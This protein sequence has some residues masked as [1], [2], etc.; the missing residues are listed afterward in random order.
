MYVPP[1]S[2]WANQRNPADQSVAELSGN[3][4]RWYRPSARALE[5][6]EPGQFDDRWGM[7]T[8]NPL[9]DDIE[10]F[11]QR[12]RSKSIHESRNSSIVAGVI[13]SH[14][15]AVVGADGP[16][17]DL[18]SVD[19]SAAAERW[20]NQAEAV[21]NEWTGQ[22]AEFT[23]DSSHYYS[24]CEASGKL[25]YAD[26]LTQWVGLLWTCG[27]YLGV[28]A[29]DPD[30][31]TN[32][33]IRWRIMNLHPSRLVQPDHWHSDKNTR[34]GIRKN[35]LGRHVGYWI[36]NDRS[37]WSKNGAEYP[38]RQVYHGYLQ[39]EPEQTRGIALMNTCI[40]TAGN[41][42]DYDTQVLA[43]AR[44]AAGMALFAFTRHP[45]A[46]YFEIPK[47]DRQQRYRQAALNHL[48]PGWELG[49]LN[50]HQPTA[51]YKEHRTERMAEIGRPAGMPGLVVRQDASGHNYS[52]ARFDYAQFI[53]VIKVFQGWLTWQVVERNRREVLSTAILNGRLARPPKGVTAIYTWPRP[54]PIDELKSADAEAAELLN[55]TLSFT[56]A[57]K[58][59]GT[60]AQR[61]VLQRKKDKRLLE[62]NGLPNVGPVE[63]TQSDG[64]KP[65]PASSYVEN[66]Q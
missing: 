32:D 29:E 2:T 34:L 58:R 49:S 20:C 15:T 45:D 22:M 30:A 4:P 33:P 1:Q 55:G 7:A 48:A 61:V 35:R 56:E 60:T 39:T 14:C 3:D 47:D 26:L 13:R 53:E 54:Q 57:C 16:T 65:R 46:P 43:A 37:S 18:Q 5:A 17:L 59:R 8:D 10:T 9:D 38:D 23:V 63:Q 41:I 6:G 11:G 50:S 40:D 31:P 52:S 28:Q 62:S 12:I 42:R 25:R 19:D 36:S 27:E 51:N 24:R 66:T 44:A 21:W 64:A